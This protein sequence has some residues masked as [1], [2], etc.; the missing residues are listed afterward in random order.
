DGKAELTCKTA[1]GSKDANGDYVSEVSLDED[2]KNCD[3]DADYRNSGGYILTGDEYFTI[4]DGDTGEAVDTIYYPNQRLAA[5]VWGDSY[6]NRLDRFTAAVAYMDGEKPYAVYMRGYYMS[7]GSERQAACAI[8]FDGERLSCSHSFDTYD[9]NNYT[10]KASSSSYKSDGAYKGVDGYAASNSKYAGEGNHNCTVAD[11]DGDGKDEVLTGAICYGFNNDKLTVEW[12]TFLE[13]GDALHI[14]DYDP[15]HD[16]YEFFTVHE[17][18]GTNKFTSTP[19]DYGMSVIDAATGDVMF[20]R[21]ASGDTGRGMMANVG[22]GGYY[23]FWGA[24]SYKALGNDIFEAINITGASSN[25]RIFWDGD[26][27]DELMDGQNGRGLNV[28]SWDGKSMAGIFST[29]DCISNNGTKANPCLQADILG[30]WREEIIMTKTS[31]DALRVYVSDI[32]TEYKMMTLM[33]DSVYRSG[34][35]NEQTGYN[36]PPHIGFYLG[37]TSFSGDIKELRILGEPNKTEYGI[38]DFL[39]TAGLRVAIVYENDKEVETTDYLVSGFDANAAGEQEVTVSYGGVDTTFTV[40]VK[41]G[42]AINDDGLITGYRDVGE[43]IIIVP[44]KIDGKAVKGFA[45]NAL[46]TADIANIYIYAD[47]LTYGSN[48]FNENTTVHG[49]EGST[50]QSYCEANNIP[51]AAISIDFSYMADVDYEDAKYKDYISNFIVTQS[52]PDVQKVSIDGITY[53]S[54]PRNDAWPDAT[55]GIRVGAE[56]L[57]TYLIPVAGEFS[58][59][60]RNSW[61][62]IND[63]IDLNTV[64]EYTLKFD[65][66]YPT[67]HGTLLL[68]LTNGTRNIDSV[69]YTADLEVD[70]WYTYTYQYDANKNIIRTISKGNS[71]IS[72]KD[73]GKY[74]EDTYGVNHI[75]FTRDPNGLI[76]SDLPGGWGNHGYDNKY[77]DAYMDNIQV[78]TPELASAKFV[79]TDSYDCPIEGAEVTMSGVYA[80][81][82]SNG[83]A[84]ISAESGQYTAQISANGYNVKTANVSLLKGV[85]TVN[86][87][88]D[89]A[90]TSTQS[91][92]FKQSGIKVKK[93]GYAIADYTIVPLHQP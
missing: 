31:Q 14:G 2:I 70:T 76:T 20:H 15:M 79:V 49:Y 84:K 73:L 55:T 75:E 60:G 91:I 40:T 51:Y 37:E 69:E 29:E 52:Q 36:Q 88:L 47:D 23:Q 53:A 30:D 71:I 50:A 35:A 85:E 83:E 66:M 12:C 38:G 80:T 82:D 68:T 65:I 42:F 74:D 45:D 90:E 54:N 87:R 43:D 10:G 5:E 46:K 19:L 57:N 21:G 6:G 3:N 58:T 92:S 72:T 32:P 9:V 18:G 7:E 33:H 59:G 64:S 89:E 67:N 63:K 11:V 22:A 34:V 13:H 1:P 41:S 25:F 17:D 28:T 62:E 39:D 77:A 8:S 48:V 93:G 78:Y 61:L 56:G 81:T 26:L 44:E 24:G 27:Y 86:V 16:G 4:F